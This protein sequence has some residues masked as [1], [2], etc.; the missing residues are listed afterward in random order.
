[1]NGDIFET[2]A[3]L[4]KRADEIVEKA[5]ARA[6]A[7]RA[8][9]DE[10]LKALAEELEKERGLRREQVEAEVAARRAQLFTEFEERMRRSMDRLDAV[11]RE[12]VAPLVEHVIK[13][14][15]ERTHGD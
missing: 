11:R 12:K 5:K 13:A 3:A 2:I 9:V 15:L 6:K 10:K 14:F 8:E 7:F 4:E 1:M